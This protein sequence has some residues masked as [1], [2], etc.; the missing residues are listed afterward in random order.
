MITKSIFIADETNNRGEVS[1][2]IDRDYADITCGIWRVKVQ[3]IVI[4]I[5]KATPPSQEPRPI[6][7]SVNFCCTPQTRRGATKQRPVKLALALVSGNLGEFVSLAG[8]GNEW[9]SFQNPPTR[10]QLTLT[11]EMIIGRKVP[12]VVEQEIPVSETHVWAH[13]VIARDA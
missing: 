11:N 12:N 4:R 10:L 1:L 13:L 3:K 7:C 9:I 8:P 6:S 2:A 5:S